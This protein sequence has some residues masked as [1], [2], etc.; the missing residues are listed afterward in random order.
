MFSF[1]NVVIKFKVYRGEC[2]TLNHSLLTA[3]PILQKITSD[4]DSLTQ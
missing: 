3:L 4:M 1:L 2:L